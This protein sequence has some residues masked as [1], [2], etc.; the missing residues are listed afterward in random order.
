MVLPAL[1]LAQSSAG[2]GGGGGGGSG[3]TVAVSNFPNPQAV[4]GTVSAV[5][6]GT[7]N[8]GL[9]GSLPAFAATPTFNIG[10][11]AG[12][13]TETGVQQVRTA[14]G[15]PFQAGGSI[16]NTAFGISGT[17]PAFAATPTFNLGTLNG[18]ATAANQSTEITALQSLVGGTKIVAAFPF[19]ETTA[20]LAAGASFTGTQHNTGAI[21]SNSIF[22]YV[23]ATFFADQ[24]GTAYLE[25]SLDASTW[26]PL[27]GTAGT[28]LAAGGSLMLKSPATMNIF[29]ARFVNGS[30]A[31]TKFAVGSMFSAF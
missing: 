30:T 10:T 6:S 28:A 29:R 11:I 24:A 23:S 7:W 27:N 5:Q 9:T 1:A 20:P 12:I 21:N 14:L 17:L 3:G 19:T 18:A 4:S 8:T 13:A 26:Y 31:Q 16:G 25:Q 15:S 22:G 2:G